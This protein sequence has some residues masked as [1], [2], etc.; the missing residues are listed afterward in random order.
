MPTA[1]RK[2]PYKNYNF[3][4]E[5]DGITQAGFSHVV[6]A[7]SS[8]DVIEYREGGDPSHVRKLPGRV[9][10]SNVVLKW[11]S[12]DSQELYNW[13]KAV[14]DGNVSRRNLT[15]V[16]LDR[17]RNPVKRWNVREAWP[18][19]YIVA[20]LDAKGNDVLIE[21]LEVANEGVELA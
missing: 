5:I 2:D 8:V 19:K 14:R 9:R 7:E 10:Y 18:T 12:T 15:I 11:G 1:K 4:V 16:L 6:I 3:L 21:E 17:V 13:W 20:P